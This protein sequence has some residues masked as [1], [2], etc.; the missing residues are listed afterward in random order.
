MPVEPTRDQYQELTDDLI[1][2]QQRAR[3]DLLRMIW[4]GATP[5]SISENY[6][7]ELQQR[8]RR[9]LLS[10]LN[11]ASTLTGDSQEACGI[12]PTGN[13]QVSAAQLQR[14]STWI[15]DS[16]R[17]EFLKDFDRVAEHGLSARDLL[18][19]VIEARIDG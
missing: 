9:G 19:A 10:Y 15:V 4:L 12:N 3:E 2:W 6:W 1:L 18:D 16:I 8:I 17:R 13:T 11:I 7:D 5:I 14:Y